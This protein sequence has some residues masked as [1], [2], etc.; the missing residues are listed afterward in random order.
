MDEIF[1]YFPATSSPPSKLPML[2]LLKQA[3]AYGLGI[4]LA[5]QNPVDLDYKGL[6]NA[7]T[8]FIGRLQTQR[9]KDRVLDGLEGASTA[10]GHAFDRPEID[11]LLS[12]L[13]RRV[14]LMNDVHEQRPVLFQTRWTLSYLR[15]PMTR[16]QIQSLMAPRKRPTGPP[17]AHPDGAVASSP[18]PASTA[19]SAA[20][21]RPVVPP[22]VPLAFVPRRATVGPGESIVYRPSILGV[23]RL[24]Y[25]DK[26]AGVDHWETLA[27]LQP[28][29]ESMPAEPWADS[30]PID[31]GVPELDKAPEAGARFAPMP[32]E[33]SRARCYADWSK[34]L[35]NYL[36]RERTLDLW[37]CP[38]VKATSTP[39]EA[40]REFRLRVAQASRERRDREVEKLRAQYA[41]KMTTLEDQIRRARE[42]L[43]R[44][45][46]EAN[47]STWDATVAMGT[48][49][50]GALFGR[51]AVTKAN[52]GRAASAAKA[53]GRAAQQHG[54]IGRAEGSLEALRRKYAKLEAEF[55]EEVSQITPPLRPEAVAMVPLPIRP[56][57][58]DITVEQVVLAWTPWKVGAVGGPEPAYRA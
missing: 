46:A 53:A 44:E 45:Q 40:E 2:T 13:G 10:T 41:P 54:D 20:G 50:L 52:V 34:S 33:L 5:T 23:A 49:V 22:D 37:I 58:T 32:P 28:I 42:R 36:Y 39:T 6:S 43:E 26:K 8:W 18:P 56:R 47:R 21:A 38:E 48:S 15:G 3:R 24:H 25:A 12:A 16:E 4:V 57:K 11:R 30:V 14:F 17:E 19:M 27:L 29:G 1:G 31:D 9:D 7:G 55:H 51:K 35:K